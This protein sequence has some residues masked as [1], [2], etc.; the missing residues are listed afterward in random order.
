MLSQALVI[1]L[2]AILSSLLTLGIAYWFIRKLID[3]KAEETVAKIT[4]RFKDDVGPELEERVAQGVRSGF[5]SLPSR[6]VIR[7][8]TRNMAKTGVDI[9]GDTLKP[10]L[11]TKGN[12]KSPRSRYS[13]DPLDPDLDD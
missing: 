9:V 3:Y 5:A 1:V 6:E 13:D 10:F 2:T 4:Q 11:K 8:T 12:Y 7:D